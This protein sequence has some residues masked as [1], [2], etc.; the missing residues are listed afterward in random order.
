MGVLLTVVGTLTIVSEQLNPAE[1]LSS[2]TK[3]RKFPRPFVAPPKIPDVMGPP[4]PQDFNNKKPP[5]GHPLPG[6]D[7]VINDV[8]KNDVIK[9][10]VVDAVPIHNEEVRVPAANVGDNGGGEEVKLDNEVR[11]G[12]G[13]RREDGDGGGMKVEGGDGGGVKVGGGEEGGGLHKEQDSIKKD[14]AELKERIKAVEEE[15]QELKVRH[16]Q[17]IYR[18]VQYLV[19][20]PCLPVL[21]I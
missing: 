8:I 1:D 11:E 3:T 4:V 13:E 12:E 15:N 10:D 5:D 19:T 17:L 18:Y 6:G 2:A 21:R 7:D 9:N 14:M 20:V 16:R